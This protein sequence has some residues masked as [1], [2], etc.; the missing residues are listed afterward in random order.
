MGEEV[1]LKLFSSQGAG[2]LPLS[3][4][5]SQRGY[6]CAN[7][8]FV[9]CCSVPGNCRPRAAWGSFVLLKTGQA[10]DSEAA[11]QLLVHLSSFSE[12]L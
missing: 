2:V 1:L 9:S 5:T 3:R 11:E 7:A 4:G 6:S 8:S 12:K 10:W